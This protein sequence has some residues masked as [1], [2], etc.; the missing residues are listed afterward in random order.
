MIV[1]LFLTLA[2]LASGFTIPKGSFNLG[3]LE[4][5]KKAAAKE[6]KPIAFVIAEKKGVAT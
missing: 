2:C 6:K 1:S 5:V 4:A 3:Q